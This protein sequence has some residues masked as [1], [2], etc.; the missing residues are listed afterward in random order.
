MQHKQLG[1]GTVLA[2][3]QGRN[4][5][6]PAVELPGLRHVVDAQDEERVSELREWKAMSCPAPLHHSSSCCD[7]GRCRE[8]PHG[9]IYRRPLQTPHAAQRQWPLLHE[10]AP[11]SREAWRPTRRSTER[12]KTGSSLKQQRCKFATGSKASTPGGEVVLQLSGTEEGRVKHREQ[13]VQVWRQ[14]R[15]AS[16]VLQLH[17]SL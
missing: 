9:H 3:A 5:V 6:G 8:G 17:A 16:H 7:L 15:L 2:R 11:L 12:R 4:G 1:L 13:P 10:G 14:Q